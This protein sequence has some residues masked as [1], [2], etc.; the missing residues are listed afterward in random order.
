M[1]VYIRVH[2]VNEVLNKQRTDLRNATY[3]LLINQ[4]HLLNL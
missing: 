3:V 4:E 2:R 1:K